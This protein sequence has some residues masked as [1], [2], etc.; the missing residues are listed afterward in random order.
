[1]QHRRISLPSNKNVSVV[2]H[3]Q[4]ANKLCVLCSESASA[5]TSSCA[6]RNK[7]ASDALDTNTH[8]FADS[9]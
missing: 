9:L 1:M 8:Y 4:S 6:N 3:F 5:L 7:S 2:S